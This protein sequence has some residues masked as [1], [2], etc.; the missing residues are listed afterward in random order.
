MEI[1]YP[2]EKVRLKQYATF[3]DISKAWKESSLPYVAKGWGLDFPDA[4]NTLQLFWG[5][6]SSPGSN[7]ANYR[8]PEYD[9]RS[10]HP[11]VLSCT[12]A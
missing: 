10:R 8:N 7:D 2:R 4:E 6:N 5:P 11:S 1:G 9:R 12:S 3:G